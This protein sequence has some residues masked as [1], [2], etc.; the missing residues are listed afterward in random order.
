VPKTKRFMGPVGALAGA[1]ALSRLLSMSQ[2]LCSA[3]P[4][5]PTSGFTALMMMEPQERPAGARSAQDMSHIADSLTL[6]T[7]QA[8]WPLC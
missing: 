2:W 3:L 5:D 6:C 8:S 7:P 1:L 4:K